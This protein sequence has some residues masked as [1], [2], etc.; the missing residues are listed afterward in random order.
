MFRLSFCLFILVFFVDCVSTKEECRKEINLQ[1]EECRSI[2]FKEPIQ[3]RVLKGHLIRLL[4]V[5]HQGSCN[6][7]CYMEPNCVSI[8][9][10]PSQGGNYICELNNAS[11]ESPGSSNLQSKQDYTHLSIENPCRSSPCFNI[12]TCQAGYT[13]EGF[14]CKCPLGFTGV[15]CKKACS[16]DFEDGIG[17]WEMTGSAFIYQP[18]FGDNPVARN[19]SAQPQGYWWVG[20]AE[21]RP[22]ESDPA[23]LQHPDGADVPK[24]TLISP[25]FRI[26]G[27]NILFLIGGGCKVNKIRAELIVNNQIVRTET[28]NCREKMYRKSWDVEEF[29]GQYA[30][31]RLIDE[32]SGSW[33]HINFDDLKG[34]IICPHDFDGK[35]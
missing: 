15:N 30:Q 22:K 14:R 34:D 33:G 21:K 4:E 31:V 10:G 24:G 1:G 28:G 13:D 18:T 35:N 12:G 26:V 7:L 6:V 3:E 2:I 8:N 11:D 19:K 20:G 32:S 23:G 17:G 16:F 25:C 29:S 27:K 9:V 5:P